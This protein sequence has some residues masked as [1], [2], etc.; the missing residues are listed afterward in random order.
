MK[1]KSI[2][3]IAGMLVVVFTLVTL[4]SCKKDDPAPVNEFDYVNSWILDNM[5]EAYYWTDKLPSSP[6]KVQKPDAFF[7]SLLNKPDDRFS[8]IQENYQDLLNSLQGVNKEAGYEF[9]LYADQ[10]NN[11]IAQILY[12]KKKSPAD[13][14]GLK[15][16]DVIDQLNGVQIT[17]DNFRD[18]FGKIIQSHIGLT[19][20]PQRL[21]VHRKT[22]RSP[23][24]NTRRIRTS[25]IR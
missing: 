11:L 19:M 20:R 23:Q 14:N 25:W 3:R 8:W 6:K 18:L 16:G 15:R 10:G 7:Q 12:V 21:S 5:K 4:Q 22:F 24:L 9:V 17:R 13:L 1:M 2:L